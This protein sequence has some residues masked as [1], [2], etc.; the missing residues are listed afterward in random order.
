MSE[1]ARFEDA[2]GSALH[3]GARDWED[4]K[5]ISSLVQDSIFP[6]T[7]MTYLRDERRFA[8]LL[9][10]F[11]WEEREATDAPRQRVQSVLVFENVMKVTMQGIDQASRELVLSLLCLEFNPTE[12]GAGHVTLTMAGDGGIRLEVE[13]IDATLKDVTRPY[14]AK[15][16]L[17]PDHGV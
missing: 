3:L 6:I 12:D 5:I 10:R 16:G 17:Q 15:S 9:N 7:E 2:E 14:A 13:A 11:R 4:L 1:D 8:L